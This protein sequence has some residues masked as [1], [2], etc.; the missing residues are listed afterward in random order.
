MARAVLNGETTAGV[1]VVVERFGDGAR[2]HLEL[3]AAPVVGDGGA[4]LGGVVACLDVTERT[5]AEQ[6]LR[7]QELLVREAAE[8]AHVG[9]WGFDPATGESD[10]TPEVARL[11]GLDPAAPPA[12]GAA[13]DFFSP[14]QRPALEA[15]LDAAVRDG[16]PHDLELLLTAANGERRWVRTICRPIVESGRVVRVRG[17]LQ[18]ITERKRGEQELRDSEQRSRV[19][20]EELGVTLNSLP[21]HVALLD[22]NGV[23][24]TVNEAW[25]QFA[26]ANCL[27]PMTTVG[28][29]YISVSRGA[30]G[31]DSSEG[32]A[33]ADGVEA[34]LRGQ[35]GQF[36]LRY[37]CH[38]PTEERWFEVIVS[39]LR[40][41]GGAVVM[42]VNVTEQAR[43]EAALRE[44]EWRF[45][46]VFEYASVGIGITDADG[47]FLQCNPAYCR[48]LGRSESELKAADL[49]S[50]IHPDDRAENMALVHRL[51]AGQIPEYELENRFLHAS[52]AAVWVHKFVTAL[53]SEPG[54]AKYLMALVTDVTERRRAEQELRESESRFRTLVDV[55]PD[56]VIVNL[57]RQVA[58]CNPAAVRLFGATSPDQI[59]GKTPFD[60]FHPADHDAIHG[61]LDRIEATGE[62]AAPR[63][64][65]IVRLD[66]AT[67]PVSVTAIPVADG[68]RRAIL[69]VIRDLTDQRRLEEQFRQ[70]QKMEAIGRLAGGVAHDFNN[71]L[72]V[73]NG[74]TDLMLM[75]MSA[76]DPKR[77]AVV[78]V[79]DAGERA[80]GLTQQ[81]LAFSRKAIV[82]PKVLDLN[83]V[84]T[85]ADKL[86]RRLIGEDVALAVTSH[87][88]PCRVTAD[89]NQL[90]Q[91]ILNLAVNARDAMPTGGRLA[92]STRVV[93]LSAGEVDGRPAGRYT[94]LTVTDTGCG[95]SDEVRAKIFE[96]FFTTKGQGKGT[97]LGL[98]TVFGIVQQ[99]GG[100]IAVESEVGRGT[101]FRVLLPEAAA[102]PQALSGET[103]FGGRGTETVLLVEDD[104]AVR[105]LSRIALES[106]GYLVVPAASGAEELEALR[107]RRGQIRL[108]VTDVIMPEMS[109]REL[110][111]AVRELA[112]GVRVLFVSGYTDDAVVRHGVVGEE[113]E[114]L[115]KPFT[116]LGLARKVREVID[117]MA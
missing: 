12:V 76:A 65:R 106:Q 54:R 13:L 39:P 21:A 60:L 82:A 50:L 5:A 88:A 93:E 75:G 23:I 67:S 52:G 108:L 46:S 66:G 34:V 22:Q 53:G 25:R 35:T 42:H 98:A 69:A 38:S 11:Y 49:A 62:P 8:L 110:A 112:P 90:D 28:V 40:E 74:Y 63:E 45:R 18:D 41:G 78:A 64:E 81:L 71:L 4:R 116:P 2:R 7:E 32:T 102:A 89:P 85:H 31:P 92:L 117:G 115:Q 56:A 99:A 17:S 94:E 113:V 70:A 51:A 79:R 15:A 114:F 86:L 104:D 30:R 107:T 84:L 1:A 105:E 61:R 72:T 14:E 20:A 111:D 10:W 109:G 59:I 3:S 73:I 26:A 68:G 47:R 9:G 48:V 6:K 91:V 83:D 57:D 33:V 80:A 27:D 95:M 19:L 16:T 87:P 24:T 103:R 97:G 96:P 43:A 101:T 100:A 44:S 29:D 77:G 36:R 37:P 55:L 58:F